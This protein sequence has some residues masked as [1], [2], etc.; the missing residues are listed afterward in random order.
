M[1]LTYS[2]FKKGTALKNVRSSE[3]IKLIWNSSMDFFSA[4]PLFSSLSHFLSQPERSGI[5]R[6]LF[7]KKLFVGRILNFFLFL[8]YRCCGRKWKRQGAHAKWHKF[9]RNV[10]S[11]YSQKWFLSLLTQNKILNHMQSGSLYLMNALQLKQRKFSSSIVFNK[12]L[13]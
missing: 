12:P 1:S 11:W 2:Y 7:V 9:K 8:L 4:S 13:K 3:R 10:S 6:K 5:V